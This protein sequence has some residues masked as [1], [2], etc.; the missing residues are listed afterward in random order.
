MNKYIQTQ[1]RDVEV[2][3]WGDKD[4]CMFC[5]RFECINHDICDSILGKNDT[6]KINED[7]YKLFPEPYDVLGVNRVC[8]RIQLYIRYGH[9]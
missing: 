5:Q 6:W 7:Y 1:L 8:D 9:E 3:S 4:K 2:T